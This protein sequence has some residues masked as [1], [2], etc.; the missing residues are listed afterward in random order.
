VKQAILVVS[1]GTSHRDTL[2]KT[3]QATEEAIGAAFPQW[4]VRRAF[5]SGMIIKKWASRDGVTID[6]VSEALEKLYQEGYSRVVVQS[7]HVMHGEEYEKLVRQV[8]PWKERLHL[9][10]GM[11]LLHQLSDYEAVAQALLSWLPQPEE[12]QAL[13]LMGHGTLHFANSCYAQLEHLLQAACPRIY[14]G[15]VEG[16]PALEQVME[17]LQRHPNLRRVML[18]PLMLVAGDHAKNDMAGE[19]DSWKCILESQGY[20][21]DCVLRG[22]GECA[23]IRQVFV[24]HCAAAMEELNSRRGTLYGVGV[25]PGDPE[26]LTVK[27]VKLLQHSDMILVPD[28][29]KQNQVAL[30]IVRD[31]VEGKTLR[32]VSTPMVRDQA[33]LQAAYDSCADLVCEL[34]DQG[35]QV[36]YITLGDPSIYSTYLYVHRRVLERGYSAQL[37]PGIPSFCA[38]AAKLNISLCEGDE[39]LI[40]L[41]ASR[42]KEPKRVNKVYMKAGRSILELQEELRQQGQLDSAAL[43]ENC[44]LPGERILPQFGDL[45][46]PTGYFSLVIS[47]EEQG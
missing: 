40:I 28:S 17:R 12:D 32:F 4:E 20:Q 8:E 33:V 31:Y 21:V 3:I 27:A 5:T 25:G 29:G 11:P 34:L 14:V 46:E 44:G 15:T 37:V 42:G 13:V 6:N 45:K 39:P 47:K 24:T 41:P 36:V 30:N 43:V 1:F 2:E 23:D 16:Y 26:L 22:L 35:K 10:L 7:A 9:S 19:E 38:A 18:A